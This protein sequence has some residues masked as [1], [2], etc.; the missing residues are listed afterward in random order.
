M[1]D[2]GAARVHYILIR[3][4][5]QPWARKYGAKTPDWQNEV[6][7]DVTQSGVVH[8]LDAA[9][10]KG[11]A[12]ELVGQR[13][14]LRAGRDNRRADSL[15]VYEIHP[16]SGH[17][18][19][20][21][22]ARWQLARG[23][24]W[25]PDADPLD[26]AA[27]P[28]TESS[29]E[30]L[31]QA[32]ERVIGPLAAEKLFDVMGPPAAVP[33]ARL[34][35]RLREA[36]KD[37]EPVLSLASLDQ[38]AEH[39]LAGYLTPGDDRRI[40]DI[41]GRFDEVFLERVLRRQATKF[42]Q[43][44]TALLPLPPADAVRQRIVAAWLVGGP[45]GSFEERA[46]AVV[47][48][49]SSTRDGIGASVWADV[50]QD[51]VERRAT[52]GRAD[53]LSADLAR[54]IGSWPELTSWALPRTAVR[55]TTPGQ[56]KHAGTTV[57][58]RP[59]NVAECG[60]TQT[61][62]EPALEDNVRG[63]IRALRT[64]PL[65]TFRTAA[66]T[67]SE[68][69]LG[70]TQA[71]RSV[72][73]RLPD[74]AAL[75]E[76]TDLV[77]G[78][79]AAVDAVRKALPDAR[80]LA[81][82]ETDV[83][84]ALATWHAAGPLALPPAWFDRIQRWEDLE[85]VLRVLAM[86]E[87]QVLPGWFPRA[88]F[89]T[90]SSLAEALYA[91]VTDP[92]KRS[93]LEQAALWIQ[94]LTAAG[95]DPDLVGDSAPGPGA[96][97]LGELKSSYAALCEEVTA[98]D[99]IDAAVA[100][101]GPWADT[102][103]HS[104]DLSQAEVARTLEG[105]ADDLA[106]L[107]SAV[108]ALRDDILR[109]VQAAE[110]PRAADQLLKGIDADVRG[111]GTLVGQL[112]TLQAVRAVAERIRGALPGPAPVTEIAELDIGHCMSDGTGGVRAAR[113]V[114]RPDPAREGLLLAD[115][116]VSIR[117]TKRQPLELC[118]ALQLP[119][120]EGRPI[121]WIEFG[122]ERVID[123]KETAWIETEGG[124]QATVILRRIPLTRQRS[125][126]GTTLK[127]IDVIVNGEDRLTKARVRRRELV[128]DEI[129][130]DMPGIELPFSDTTSPD[131]MRRHPLG[132]QIRFDEIARSLKS[133]RASV[134]VAAP[135]RF[136]KTTLLNAVTEELADSE[137]IA[138]GPIAS[139]A[140]GSPQKAF[141]EACEQLGIVLGVHVPDWSGKKLPDEDT[142]DAAR[143]EAARRGKKAICLLFDEA[144]A[145]FGG[146][147]GK[148]VAELLKVRLEE[149]W[150]RDGRGRAPLRIALVGQLHLQRLIRGQLD[151]VF[152]E[153]WEEIEIR[154]D[155]I[156]R[157]LRESTRGVLQSTAGARRLVANVSRNLYIL[158]VILQEIRSLLNE[159]QRSWFV[160]DDVQTA[161]ERYIQKALSL[162]SSA[163]ASYVRDPLNA[164]EDLTEWR[165][166]RAYPVALAWAVTQGSGVRPRA[167]RIDNVRKLLEA[168]A[169]LYDQQLTV[170]ASTIEDALQ[171]LRDSVV[172]A[173]DE[174]FHSELLEWF[175]NRLGQSD[176]PLRDPLERDALRALSV[177]RVL[178][179]GESLLER[180]GEGGQATVFLQE[181]D[182]PLAWRFVELTDEHSHA[183]FVEMCHALHALEG[184]RSRL[185]G[186]QSLAVVKQAGITVEHPARGA[187][188]YEWVEGVDLSG[189]V[190]QLSDDAVVEIGR[191]VA[192][193][194]V[195]LACRGVVHRDVRPNNIVRG[196]DG[197][198]VLVD[199]GLAKLTSRAPRTRVE[200][201]KYLAPEI[202]REDPPKWSPL[203][204][205]YAL[206]VTL[207]ELRRSQP[208][209]SPLSKL[210]TGA[211]SLRLDQRLSAEALAAEFVDLTMTMGID[212]RRRNAEGEYQALVD[213]ACPEVSRVAAA[214]LAS[215]VS[216]DLGV[217]S[218]TERLAQAA[219][220][221]DD[222]YDAWLRTG[223]AGDT[224]P[225]KSTHLSGL[226]TVDARGPKKLLKL[227]TD[228]VI[229]TG[230]LRHAVGHRNGAEVSLRRARQKL[231]MTPGN[232]GDGI[233]RNA[234][235]ETAR[236]LETVAE[237]SGVRVIVERWVNS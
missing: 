134:L 166:I 220:F 174:R 149:A 194:L 233:L 127:R 81:G 221:L 10:D 168:W 145:L 113:I 88:L 172:I 218:G 61:V 147:Q 26:A 30:T 75:V 236:R 71:L 110:G 120:L 150:G 146:R 67:A 227:K 162:D 23:D 58:Q 1:A 16:R 139:A 143:A 122:R 140:A 77:A 54:A 128:F 39:I 11:P 31:T 136:G 78:M 22:A 63:R 181:G 2:S 96:D 6:F 9:T 49:G 232:G 191:Q 5:L 73:A 42:T 121:E 213:S 64:R 228:Q 169:K 138:I 95:G 12:V 153:R 229:A 36:F 226:E 98:R 56:T 29:D 118:L 86:P 119:Y 24:R 224:G 28:A 151:A 101:L 142:F 7:A 72:L 115:L 33:P 104:A 148:S 155:H 19:R 99:Q 37:L 199:F 43:V 82:A 154:P 215:M 103:R 41:H 17:Q 84:A 48:W 35:V 175:F 184:T 21:W 45:P 141:A 170:S 171:E 188:V 197:I 15:F 94:S 50:I 179:P 107:C 46:A 102:F 55:E 161:V 112:G 100:R 185:S 53:S 231:R 129:A 109:E 167:A 200:P 106:A 196:N 44:L 4:F 32:I 89:P 198:P 205:V 217:F 182:P 116:P 126:D 69:L 173:P 195:V 187:V 157:L 159:E 87:L 165:P 65:D 60:S 114:A 211:R 18:G 208:A 132:I 117:G 85:R 160:R 176:S 34:L 3:E 27:V 164:S 202:I 204:D 209:A 186:Y 207:D 210:L 137:V 83:S 212:A 214:Y 177:D 51:A 14:S 90:E 234:V 193:A 20:P 92:L 105:L 13:F 235:I 52:L 125:K 180:A 70:R 201:S 74:P 76:G 189:A 158:R 216:T 124:V 91:S 203:S 131:E 206:S 40:T 66:I 192:E 130:F 62:C 8:I 163:F 183:A 111:L 190:G 38:L 93:V 144:Q 156:E 225:L 222:L 108:P 178:P 59:S 80:Q 230:H 57:A 79:S 123:V 152:T 223:G 133:G 97:P 25:L 47:R 219:A 135:R 68:Q 237:L